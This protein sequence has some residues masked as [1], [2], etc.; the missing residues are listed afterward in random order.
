MFNFLKKK[1]MSKIRTW[2]EAQKKINQEEKPIKILSDATIYALST[3]CSPEKGGKG[4][5]SKEVLTSFERRVP[6]NLEGRVLANF[7]R[8]VLTDFIRGKV[9]TNYSGDASLFEV[10]CYLYFR[11]DLWHFTNEM[12]KYRETRETVVG[13]LINQF[14]SVFSNALHL[15]NI[16]QILQSRLDLYGRLI[17]ESKNPDDE[18]HRHLTLLIGQTRGNILPKI[19]DLKGFKALPVIL[20]AFENYS[21]EAEIATFEHAMVPICLKNIENFYKLTSEDN[22]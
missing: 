13:Y 15:E 12:Q 3:F 10:G 8:R 18:V 14:L 20:D 19:Y 7:E 1:N 4:D 5:L 9:L 11:I 6:T 17:R 21:L 2:A 22:K 16:E